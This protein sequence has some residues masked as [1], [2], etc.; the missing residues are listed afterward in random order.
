MVDAVQRD[1]KA[2]AM[3]DITPVR[4]EARDASGSGVKRNVGP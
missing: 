3:A 4:R 2:V 1:V